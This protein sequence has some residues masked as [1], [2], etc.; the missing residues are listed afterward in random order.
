MIMIIIYYISLNT[1]IVN[2]NDDNNYILNIL[3]RDL[4]HL[5]EQSVSVMINSLE[6]VMLVKLT[7]KLVESWK[8][9]YK[10]RGET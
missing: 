3:T 9:S 4:T 7:E 1:K 10:L 8:A 5:V 6:R 2:I